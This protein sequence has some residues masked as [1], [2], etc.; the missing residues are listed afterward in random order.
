MRIV[1]TGA[2]V[3]IA[4]GALTRYFVDFAQVAIRG[5]HG[6]GSATVR[7]L[8]AVHHKD[9]RIEF[10]VRPSQNQ[11]CARSLF[12]QRGYSPCWYLLRHPERRLEI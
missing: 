6:L 11:P 10:L 8:Y 12:P 2:V 5:P 3:A 1:L 4:L 7:P 9:G